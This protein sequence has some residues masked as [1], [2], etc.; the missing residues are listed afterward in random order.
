[1]VANFWSHLNSVSLRISLTELRAANRKFMGASIVTPRREPKQKGPPLAEGWQRLRASSR[2][3]RGGSLSRQAVQFPPR[4]A[5]D[6]VQLVPLA[7]RVVRRRRAPGGVAGE[8]APGK[9]DL[10]AICFRKSSREMYKRRP[11]VGFEPLRGQ[12]FKRSRGLWPVLRPRSSWTAAFFPAALG[13]LG[14]FQV[15]NFWF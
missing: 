8:L 11:R 12:R 1:M 9:A 5:P 15:T 13:V 2:R 10:S 4:N 7:A 14:G 6:L 3:H